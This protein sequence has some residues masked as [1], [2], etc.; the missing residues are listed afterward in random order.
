[1]LHTSG[2]LL[3]YFATAATSAALGFVAGG[4]LAFSKV[5]DLYAR[6][7]SIEDYVHSQSVT[8]QHLSDVLK[9]L[10]WEHETINSAR[11]LGPSAAVTAAR[12]ALGMIAS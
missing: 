5:T 3:G 10:L 8:I 1:M 4:M 2:L 11:G 6:L 9:N 7:A 12:Q